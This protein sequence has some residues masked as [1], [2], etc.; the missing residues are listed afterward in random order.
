MAGN[1]WQW[2]ATWYAPEYNGRVVQ[3]EVHL[4]RIIRG[5]SWANEDSFV[6]VNYRNF[7][8]PDVREVYIGFRVAVNG[9]Q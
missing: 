7:N 1:I 5:G 2:T 4:Y 3:E 6:A 9:G 8:P